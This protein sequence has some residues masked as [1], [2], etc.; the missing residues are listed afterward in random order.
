ME[1]EIHEHPL[2][3]PCLGTQ[4]DENYV[5]QILCYDETKDNL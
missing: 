1:K 4:D 3:I 2:D 5:I